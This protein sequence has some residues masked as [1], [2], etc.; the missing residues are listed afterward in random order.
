MSK[1]FLFQTIQFIQTVL[2]EPIQFIISMQFNSV[3]P[4]DMTLS[5]A[6]APGQNGPGSDGNDGVLCILQS[7]NV[8]GTSPSDCL[9]SYPGHWL[10][11][12]SYPS[13]EMKS[14]YSTAPADWAIASFKKFE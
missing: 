14:V 7:S 8:T 10:E 5:G 13:A 1:T 12:G 11:E 2:I 9:V 6:I 3:K 4:I